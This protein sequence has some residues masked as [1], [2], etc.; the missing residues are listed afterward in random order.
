VVGAYPEGVWLVELAPLSEGALVPQAV[1]GALGVQ[2]QPNQPL[3]ETLV[4]ALRDKRVLLVL[5]NCEHLADSVARLADVLLDS[6]PHL[7]VLAT[8]REPLDVIGEV[9]WTVPT[10]SSPSPGIALSVGE[11]EGFESVRLF[12]ARARN[13]DLSFAFAPGNAHVHSSACCT[14]PSW[15]PLAPVW[16]R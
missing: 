8:S 4:E 3:V 5:D 2:E 6:C 13:R 12:L 11:L 9:R 1:A 16:T 15:S 14:S 7:R 10:L